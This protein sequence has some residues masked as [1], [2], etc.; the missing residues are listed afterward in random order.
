[1]QAPAVATVKANAAGAADPCPL[2]VTTEVV[3]DIRER[4]LHR[5]ALAV[6]A[7]VPTPPP[8]AAYD[9]PP[10][11]PQGGTVTVTT[12]TLSFAADGTPDAP[13][14][15]IDIALV[16]DDDTPVDA[17]HPADPGERRYR[18]TIHD[19]SVTFAGRSELAVA[20][21]AQAEETVRPGKWSG[22]THTR[23]AAIAANPIPPPP[24]VPLPAFYPYWASLPD[25]A[26]VS[27]APVSWAP[28]GAW[29]YRVYEATEAALRAAC[30]VPGPVLTDGFGA[31]M[32]ALFDLYKDADNL[33]KLK[34]AFRKLGDEPVLPPVIDGTMQFEALLPRGSALIHCYVVAGV[35]ESNVVSSWPQP[36]ADGRK[37]F[38]G[39]VIP[40]LRR[41]ALPQIRAALDGAGVPQVTVLLDG[42]VPATQIRLYRAAN[43]ILARSTGTMQ[44]IASVPSGT[45]APALLEAHGDPRPVR[46]GQLVTT[47]VPRCRRHRR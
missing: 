26:G 13:P 24:P 42:A 1:M 30:G 41:L 39:Y 6:D 33:P 7:Y 38:D 5:L 45:A 32:Q 23:E 29:R 11:A 44:L 31:R 21:Y 47:A 3:W 14:A 34:K 19:L 16:H 4:S 20:V 2:T 8:P 18:I 27:Y 17:A 36:D 22:W 40:R 28:F 12:P 9:P 46:P 25:A 15:G 10:D 35:T 43:A 37:A